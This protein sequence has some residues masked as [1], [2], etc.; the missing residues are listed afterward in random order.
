[1]GASLRER[2]SAPKRGGHTT[3]LF[4]TKRICAVAAW[5]FDN[6]QA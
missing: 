4:S 6:P 3:I 1:M 2:G 5:C